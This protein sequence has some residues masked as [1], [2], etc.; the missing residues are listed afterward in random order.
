M[1]LCHW[2]NIALASSTS[3]LAVLLVDRRREVTRLADQL[4]KQRQLN[5]ILRHRKDEINK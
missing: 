4:F 1:Q 5:I 3:V 2:V